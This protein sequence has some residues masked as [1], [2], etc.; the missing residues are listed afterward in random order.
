MLRSNPR[1]PPISEEIAEINERRAEI[2]R[3]IARTY[4]PSDSYDAEPVVFGSQKGADEVVGNVCSFDCPFDTQRMIC[5]EVLNDQTC[6]ELDGTQLMM[7]VRT[8]AGLLQERTF[9]VPNY[10][11]P[12]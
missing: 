6:S 1:P 11:V 10:L 4:L 12:E 8:A 9:C 5:L 3:R 2:T 7:M